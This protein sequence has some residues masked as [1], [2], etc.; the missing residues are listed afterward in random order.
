MLFATELLPDVPGCG[1]GTCRWA[2]TPQLVPLPEEGLARFKASVSHAKPALG[3]VHRTAI[4]HFILV[5]AERRTCRHR[6]LG[7]VLNFSVTIR[8]EKI[9]L[10]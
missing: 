1:T 4:H 3:T 6:F 2:N 10:V 8:T 9:A 7:H 5:P